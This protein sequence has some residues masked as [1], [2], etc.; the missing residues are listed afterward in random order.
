MLQLILH[1]LPINTHNNNKSLHDY[2]NLYSGSLVYW[3]GR[4]TCITQSSDICLL[5]F[6]L[7]APIQKG[8]DKLIKK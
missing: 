4:S 2:N 6:L 7:K 8:I 1:A 3:C 5:L